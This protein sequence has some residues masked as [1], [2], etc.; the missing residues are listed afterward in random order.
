MFFYIYVYFERE[1]ERQVVSGGGVDRE[2]KNLKQAPGFELS[3]QNWAQGSN[4][5]TSRS[6]RELKSDA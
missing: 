3:A 2:R 1:R 6:P 4:S 5:W